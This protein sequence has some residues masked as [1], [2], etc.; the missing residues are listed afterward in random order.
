MAEPARDV[1]AKMR[2]VGETAIAELRR[3]GMGE[4]EIRRRFGPAAAKAQ[5]APITKAPKRDIN[6]WAKRMV[7]IATGEA[8]NARGRGQGT[9]RRR[10]DDLKG[11]IS[12][13]HRSAPSS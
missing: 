13:D 4:E 5:E 2:Q 7:D 3:H 12:A 6:E 10:P 1:L 8:T 9:S 11:V